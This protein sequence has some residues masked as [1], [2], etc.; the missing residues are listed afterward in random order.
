MTEIPTP[1]PTPPSGFVLLGHEP[2]MPAPRWG[3][4]AALGL[5]G[6]WFL[7]SIG[8]ALAVYATGPSPSSILIS[9]T[10][11]VPTALTSIAA[12]FMARRRG[13]GAASDFGLRFSWTE[14]GIGIG[15]GGSLLFVIGLM[16]VI[17][18]TVMGDEIPVAAQAVFEELRSSP[19][20]EII[21]FMGML[22]VAPIGEEILFRG[23]LYGAI[24]R[25]WSARWAML[26]SSVAF[27]AAHLEPE[28]LIIL[29]P[30]GLALGELR[31]RR[32]NLVT[33]ISAHFVINCVAAL[34]LLASTMA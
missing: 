30:L 7:S 33:T 8:L 16:A 28:R 29:L 34:G 10:A 27:A 13:N 15:V 20:A 4:G 1:V 23:V 22:I 14:V 26:I 31:L 17:A 2:R 12:V 24:E 3:I 32:R 19:L 18:M 6:F 9:L 5:L 11:V 25:A 21:F